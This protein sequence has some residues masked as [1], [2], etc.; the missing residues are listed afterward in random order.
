[1]RKAASSCWAQPCSIVYTGGG[2]G[3]VGVITAVGRHCSLVHLPR[4]CDTA[5]A[6]A[7]AAFLMQ[8]ERGS[9]CHHSAGIVQ[10]T[11]LV[12]KLH[13]VHSS[14]KRH[15]IDP[16]MS[17]SFSEWEKEQRIVRHVVDTQPTE[18]Q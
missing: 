5:A 11:F 8:R 1:M 13:E 3:L 17:K 15:C 12:L 14:R 16:F 7:M 4:S 9:Y 18:R 10:P 2:D 6:V